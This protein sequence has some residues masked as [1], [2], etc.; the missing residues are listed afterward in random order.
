M[1]SRNAVWFSQRDTVR[2]Y[3]AILLFCSAHPSLA[4]H[5]LIAFNRS[6]D[7]SSG[8]LCRPHGPLFCLCSSPV[9]ISLCDPSRGPPR[10][11]LDVRS[12]S[13]ETI[14]SVLRRTSLLSSR[15]HLHDRRRANFISRLFA[16]RCFPSAL[17]PC[18]RIGCEALRC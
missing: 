1:L 13:S 7:T 11:L 10:G 6:R 5:E 9:R 8:H 17:S 15:R 4:A 14:D 12:T 16:S 18:Q 3:I 2:R